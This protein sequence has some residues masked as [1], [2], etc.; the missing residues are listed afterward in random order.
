MR[1][2]KWAIVIGVHL[3]GGL[4]AA[5]L[6]WRLSQVLRPLFEPTRG[7]A[8][9]AAVAA[10]VALWIAL[11]FGIHRLPPAAKKR[12]VII[13]TFT[14]GLF[15]VLEFYLPG[16]S[17]IFFWR[18]GRGN[19]FSPMVVTV[20]NAV[21]VI[22]GFTFFLAAFSLSLVH[23]KNIAARR[24]GY[25]NSIAFFIAFLAMAV[26]GLWATYGPEANVIIRR[27]LWVHD[28]TVQQVFHD[29]LFNSMYVALNSTL[30][31]VLAF[32]MAT[33]AFR[34]FRIRSA[35]A[36]FM[37]IAAFICMLG[38]VPLG[39]WLTR[40]LPLSGPLSS[41]RMEAMAN[42]TLGVISM[43]GLRAVLFGILVGY[44][45]MSL[46]IWLSLERGAFFEQEL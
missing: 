40:A 29:Y 16:R 21:S 26:F 8:F 42:W 7:A 24:P 34:A 1:A 46:R 3:G 20:G 23:G 11:M 37:M 36:A 35:E 19:P 33:A 10:S 31:S 28:L 4:A 17:A 32:Y 25:Y 14:A 27:F 43:A 12:V 44:L 18:A 38:Q 41:L 22:A 13:A 2:R 5:V 9:Y 45:A 39:M 15:Y 6:L 30:F